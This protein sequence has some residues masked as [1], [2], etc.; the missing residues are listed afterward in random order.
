MHVTDTNEA[1]LL[2]ME[3]PR[4]DGLLSARVTGKRNVDHESRI[5][6]TRSVLVV[7]VMPLRVICMKIRRQRG[8]TCVGYARYIYPARLHWR[9]GCIGLSFA[10]LWRAD[11]HV[12][13]LIPGY[14]TLNWGMQFVHRDDAGERESVIWF[15][16]YCMNYFR[17]ERISR[18]Y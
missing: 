7:I 2:R 18:L 12:A 6:S 14:E 3:E 13:L 1:R 10:R 11:E 5:R 17:R 9:G 4:E 16:I 8:R 15:T